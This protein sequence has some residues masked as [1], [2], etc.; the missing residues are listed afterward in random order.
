MAREA[1]RICKEYF[2]QNDR[3]SD[4]VNFTLYNGKEVTKPSDFITLDPVIS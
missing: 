1:D 2:D 3:F 4:L